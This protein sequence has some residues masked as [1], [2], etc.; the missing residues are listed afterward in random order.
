MKK[1]KK[2]VLLTLKS[3]KYSLFLVLVFQF[4]LYPKID[5]LFDLLT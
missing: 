5:I 1:N 3:F 4:L 2:A